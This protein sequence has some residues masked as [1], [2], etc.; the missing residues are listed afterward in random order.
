MRNDYPILEFDPARE[1]IIEPARTVPRLEGMPEHCVLCFFREVIEGLCRSGQ[2][3][4]ITH[5]RS[6]VGRHPVYAVEVDGRR[7]AVAHPG[8]GAPFAAGMLEELIA[9]GGR[10]FI[11]AGGCGVLDGG[12]A[13]GHAIVPVSAVRD[14]GTSYHYLPPAREV[15]AGG[16]GLAAL[17]QVL[18]QRRSPYV[19]GKTWTTDAVYRE[20]PEKVRLR[21]EEGCLAVEMEAA[22]FFAVAQFR[23]VEFAQLLYAGYDVSG[24]EWDPRD[25]TGNT[26]V[27]EALFWLAVEA[28]LL[29]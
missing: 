14:E 4:E 29:L 18:K 5:Q 15:T 13:A 6:E 21:R 9:R 2:A 3:R 1:A 17:E 28:C 19:V 8:L 7:V 22:A 23:G 24:S 26:S 25:W 27:R 10:K 11:A 20:T 16:A 12:I